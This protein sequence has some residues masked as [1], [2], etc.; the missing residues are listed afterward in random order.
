LNQVTSILNP[1]DFRRMAHGDLPGFRDLAFDFFNDTRRRMTGWL[2]LI[3]SGNLNQ[4]RD[5]LHR[6]KGGASLFGLERLVA[7]LSAWEHAPDATTIRFDLDGFERELGAA[8]EEV[9][10]IKEDGEDPPGKVS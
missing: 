9:L 5:E 10:A 7:L 6:C 4:F 3:E 1:A 2:A 8:E